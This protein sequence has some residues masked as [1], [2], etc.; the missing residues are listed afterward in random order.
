MVTFNCLYFQYCIILMSI[1]Q[2]INSFSSYTNLANQNILEILFNQN[3]N[4]VYYSINLNR[5]S[6]VNIQ[7]HTLANGHIET[8]DLISEC[9]EVNLCYNSLDCNGYFVLNVVLFAASSDLEKPAPTPFLAASAA[10]CWSF[11]V[12]P[13]PN[14]HCTQIWGA[15]GRRAEVKRRSFLFEKESGEAATYALS[16]SSNTH[17]AYIRA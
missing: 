6:K 13:R 8:L 12:L 2:Q 16:S 17:W 1:W 4:T 14:G 3:Q 15:D 5:I 11:F 9:F 7:L 10:A